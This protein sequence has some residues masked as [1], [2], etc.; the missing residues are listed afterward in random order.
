[1]PM[2]LPEDQIKNLP[3]SKI[4]E[5]VWAAVIGIAATHHAKAD[6][7]QSSDTDTERLKDIEEQTVLKD[8][9]AL[10]MAG[11]GA[12][13]EKDIIGDGTSVEHAGEENIETAAKSAPDSVDEDDKVAQQA[14]QDTGLQ[15]TN[16]PAQHD[17]SA[18]IAAVD[19]EN[20]DPPETTEAAGI[21]VEQAD[22]EDSSESFMSSVMST[23]SPIV[24]GMQIDEGLVT[25]LGVGAVAGIAIVATDEDGSSGSPPANISSLTGTAIDGYVADATVWADIDGDGIQDGDETTTTD[26]R[27]NFTFTDDVP[28]GTTV[29]A[30]GSDRDV[31]E[32]GGRDVITGEIVETTMIA[33]AIE[34]GEMVISPLTT[35]IVNGANEDDLKQVLGIPSDV[36]LA[37]FDPVAAI[38]SD[39]PELQQLGEDVFTAAQ[40]VM[41]ALQVGVANG[42]SVE[43]IADSLARGIRFPT[44]SSDFGDAVVVTLGENLG[45]IVNNV[46]SAIDNSL[47]DG[48][49]T[50]AINSGSFEQLAETMDVVAIAQTR[51]VNTVE[52]FSDSQFEVDPADW[53]PEAIQDYAAAWKPDINESNFE[54]LVEQGLSLEGA[55]IQITDAEFLQSILDDEPSRNVLQGASIG[56]DDSLAEFSDILTFIGNDVT[57]TDLGDY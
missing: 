57:V 9:S 37:T 28:A 34:G 42:N 31:S 36:D 20:P 6:D 48:K 18:A 43:D 7:E 40:Q 26:N 2:K 52:E 53:T 54:F 27:G 4:S 10:M 29:S 17:A 38:T 39:D 47:S 13:A 16:T 24:S 33:R 46:N 55:E 30:L 5:A 14:S 15:Q 25:L 32:V 8:K 51:L 1:M 44:D 3:R 11:A 21:T 50:T 23:V 41:T 35:L 19:G 56:I 12:G 45:G 22:T 49:L